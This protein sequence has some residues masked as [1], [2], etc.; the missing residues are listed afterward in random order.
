[1]RLV[2]SLACLTV[3]LAGC[4]SQP[5]EQPT[6][7][8]PPGP[9]AHAPI[10]TE[11]HAVTGTLLG[12]PAGA[13]VELALLHVDE[14]RRPERL[15]GS[16]RLRGNGQPLPFLLRFNTEIF[17]TNQPV[18]LRGRVTQDD[19]LTM[20]LPARRIATGDNQSLGALQVVPTP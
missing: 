3:L 14:K 7:I 5:A 4:A 8:A 15:L 17:D 10:E 16:L 2:A 13:E 11:L 18:E 19:R 1:M 6:P 12:V 20:V 9:P